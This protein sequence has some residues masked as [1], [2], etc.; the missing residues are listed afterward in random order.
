MIVGLCGVSAPPRHH[1]AAGRSSWA[2]HSMG[3]SPGNEAAC[4]FSLEGAGC[5]FHHAFMAACPGKYQ[6]GRRSKQNFFCL[7]LMLL[8]WL[9]S[10]WIPV[11][12]PLGSLSD[13]P[14]TRTVT[15]LYSCTVW[16]FLVLW[17]I[18]CMSD[19]VP[20]LLLSRK[21]YKTHLV[22]SNNICSP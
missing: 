15:F 1:S 17:P 2:C 16:C 6:T 7:L 14:V 9:T 10:S 22:T 18:E 8:C 4:W 5:C 19:K 12:L 20:C 21:S 3:G 13:I 11:V